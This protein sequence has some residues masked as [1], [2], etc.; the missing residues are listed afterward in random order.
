MYVSVCVCVFLPSPTHCVLTVW[1]FRSGP[2][3]EST[4]VGERKRVRCEYRGYSEKRVHGL[5]EV[6]VHMVRLDH[7]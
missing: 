5:E 4:R 1:T 6:E 3:S 2:V 7:S